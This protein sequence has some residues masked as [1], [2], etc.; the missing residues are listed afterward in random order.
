MDR[1]IA[2]Y[3]A[4]EDGDLM[5]CR[6]HGVAYQKDMSNLV[7]YDEAYYNKCLSYEDQEI[8]RKINDGRIALVEKFFS[9]AV[10]DVGI[11]S[12]EFIKRRPNTYGHDINPVAIEWLKRNDLWANHLAEFGAYTMWDVVEHIEDPWPYFRNIGLHCFLFISIPVFYGLGGIRTSKHYRPNEHLYYFT[13]E[14]LVQWL[15]M[16]GFMAVDRQDFEIQAG[17]ESIY[18][19]AFKRYRWPKWH[20]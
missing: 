11:G 12:G 10:C 5:L 20:S 19:Y 4:E 13:D 9:G 15:D 17:R 1:I 14:G 16:H 3:P 2:D 8:A 18:S 7:A 6:D